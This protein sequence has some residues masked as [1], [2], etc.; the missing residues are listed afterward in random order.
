M[1]QPADLLVLAASDCWCGAAGGSLSLCPP[2]QGCLLISVKG[3][4]WGNSTFYEMTTTVEEGRIGKREGGLFKN[5]F[6]LSN[7]NHK[8]Q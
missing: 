2:T 7:Q 5:V 3:G 4:N 8:I 6:S 1:E